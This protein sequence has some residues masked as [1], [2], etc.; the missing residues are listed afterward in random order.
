MNKMDKIVTYLDNTL[1]ND[2]IPDYPGA[3]NGLQLGDLKNTQGGR[4]RRCRVALK[5]N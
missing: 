3:I 2:D 5:G 1:K 4:S